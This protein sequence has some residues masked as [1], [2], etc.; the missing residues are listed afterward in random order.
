MS[1]KIVIWSLIMLT[2]FIA[3]AQK[4]TILC[5]AKGA[6]G[7]RVRLIIYDD[8]V[9]LKEKDI[10]S[11]VI[12]TAGNFRMTVPLTEITYAW[13]RIDYYKGDLYLR[14][15]TTHHYNLRGLIFNDQTD[16]QNSNLEPLLINVQVADTNDLL[17]LSI[18]KFNFLYN[19]FLIENIRDLRSQKF[20]K[21]FTSFRSMLDSVFT[22]SNLEY[23]KTYVKYRLASLEMTSNLSSSDHIFREFILDQP[24]S[25]DHV[26]Y[27]DF[28]SGF[29]ESYFEEVGR[30]VGL[31]E[32]RMAVNEYKS[33]P[34]LYEAMSRDS[35]LRNEYLLETAL[36]I[37]LKYLYSVPGFSKDNI[38]KILKQ[39]VSASK[40]DKH[41]MIAAHVAD[42]LTMF[43]PGRPAPDFA[44][45]DA[46]G[47]SVHLISL[48]GKF[49]YIAFFTSQNIAC[50][51]E[52]ELM[53]KL[54]EKYSQSVQ[55]IGIC[56]DREYM[57]MYHFARDRKYPWPLLHY[58]ADY[59]LLESYGVKTY[60][61]FVLLDKQGNFIADPAV[62]P[63]Q[64]AEMILNDVIINSGKQ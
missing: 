22:N 1:K 53:R 36:L 40:F 44:L 31:T 14:P 13:L 28:L 3:G 58:N 51:E 6:E 19:R 64:N 25:I 15:N 50:I 21:L 49:V 12:D 46:G 4:T 61:Y 33:Y 35:L 34:A 47:D 38:I 11:A 37:T 42:V 48:K 62:S 63:S 45:P 20:K 2:A 52:F 23:F 27:M 17:N 8:L 24:I 59:S 54:Y 56:C 43:A 5:A 39:A 55:F 41:R 57:K 10:A 16:N 18:Q 29:F 60:P 30:P 26:E 7:K 32:L 9:S